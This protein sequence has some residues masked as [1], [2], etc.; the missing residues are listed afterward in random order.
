VALGNLGA[1]RLALG[2]PA[3]ARRLLER[4][5]VEHR[6]AIATN[7]RGV[8][9]RR[10]LRDHLAALA[11]ALLTL[12]DH[13]EA[14]RAAAEILKVA[15]DRPGARRDAARV[16]A[17]CVPLAEGDTKLA[18][19]PRQALADGYADRAIALLREA[20]ER[21]DKGG[22]RLD[23]DADLAS[24]RSRDAFRKLLTPP[25][26]EATRAGDAPRCAGDGPI[27]PPRVAAA[28]PGHPAAPRSFRPRRDADGPGGSTRRSPA[29]APRGPRRTARGWASSRS[30]RSHACRRR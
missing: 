5:A 2:A 30:P 8:D 7:P 14:A 19:G 24:L 27:D 3:E 23:E 22:G 20:I 11:K 25:N 6:A 1:L 29:R 10:A 4:A 17:R 18:D 26:V 15:T 28:G 16:L 12:G 9:S 13:A 21:G